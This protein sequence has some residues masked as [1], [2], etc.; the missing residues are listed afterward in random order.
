M[1]RIEFTTKCRAY[2]ALHEKGDIAEVDPEWAKLCIALGYAKP[3][4]APVAAAEEVEA[5]AEV[6][7]AKASK[8]ARKRAKEVE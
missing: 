5:E 4:G 3:Y 7:E 2:F 8:R 1:M 6:S